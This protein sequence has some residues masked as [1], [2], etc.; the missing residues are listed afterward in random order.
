ML[1]VFLC[2]NLNICTYI[3]IEKPLCHHDFVF[4]HAIIL[5]NVEVETFVKYVGEGKKRFY[6]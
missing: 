2:E 6:M 5:L 4:I 3:E 1:K